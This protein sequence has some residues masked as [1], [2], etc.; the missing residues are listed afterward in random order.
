MML[1]RG[2]VGGLL[3]KHLSPEALVIGGLGSAG[4]TWREQNAPQPTYYASDPMGAGVMM[5]LGLALAQPKRT[6]FYVGGDGDLVMNLGCL[7][8]VV[9][10]GASNLKIAIFDNGRYE[11]GGGQ[12]LAGSGSYSLA[13][14]AGQS[15]FPHAESID[16]PDTAEAA[17]IRLLTQDGLAF[18]AFSIAVEASPYGPPPRWSQAEDRA[19]FMRRLAGEI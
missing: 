9:G 11:T 2:F 6:V 5:A 7:L 17:V 18:A 4:R 15:G 3:R 19:I 8:T 1:R 12:S 16:D 10:S 14:I 13:G